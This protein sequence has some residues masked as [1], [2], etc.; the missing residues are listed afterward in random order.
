M[1]TCCTFAA[2]A[3]VV[4]LLLLKNTVDGWILEHFQKCSIHFVN[5]VCLLVLMF[6]L[7]EHINDMWRKRKT[8]LTWY[9]IALLLACEGILHILMFHENMY[10]EH[11]IMTAST[12]FTYGVC[13]IYT[14]DSAMHLEFCNWLHNQLLLS[15]IIESTTHVTC[16]NG[17]MTVHMVL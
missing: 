16:V 5:V 3:M 6:H 12:H 13:K 15:P 1:L 8:F 10:C 4:P 14:R 17:L 7:N 9:S 2:S 11:C